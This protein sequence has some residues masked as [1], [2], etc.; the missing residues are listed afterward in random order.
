MQKMNILLNV[1]A[2][3]K[4]MQVTYRNN[5]LQGHSVKGLLGNLTEADLY[6]F[7]EFDVILCAN[8][9]TCKNLTK[10][11][12]TNWAGGRWIGD[13]KVLF[14][15]PLLHHFTVS[16]GPYLHKLHV[17][18]LNRINHDKT[19]L[20]FTIT[21]DPE[22]FYDFFMANQL[23]ASIL[24]Y[25]IETYE[26]NCLECTGYSFYSEE[27]G[28]KNMVIHGFKN[29]KMIR[30]MRECHAYNNVPVVTHNGCFDMFYCLLYKMPFRKWYFDT[31]YFWNA[32]QAELKKSLAF[33]SSTL[34]YDYE[35][36]KDDKRTRGKQKHEYNIK[37]CQY[38][39]RSLMAMLEIIPDWAIKQA[40]E[41]MLLA[42]PALYTRFEGFKVDKELKKK[43]FFDAGR[44]INEKE[45][46]LR[47]SADKPD[48]NINSPAQLNTIIYDKFRAVP[49]SGTRSTKV[50]TL[51]KLASHGG[52]IGN[53]CGNLLEYRKYQKAI[54]AYFGAELVNDRLL[55]N[56]NVDGTETG[57][58][59]CTLSALYK[60]NKEKGKKRGNV[61]SQIQNSPPYF[62]PCLIAD[63]G[64][65]LFN[66]DYGQAD[67]RGVAY[68]SN[69][70]DMITALED[71]SQMF[72]K[73]YIAQADE[74]KDFYCYI[75]SV[76]FKV[77]IHKSK[78]V[79]SSDYKL[80]QMQK[81]VCHQ[82][83]YMSGAGAIIE[84]CIKDLGVNFI[85][86]CMELLKYRGS[87]VQ[88]I[89][90]VLYLYFNMFDRIKPWWDRVQ[91]ELIKCNGL[92]ISPDGWYR[93]FHGDYNSHGVLRAAV[94]HLPQHL[95]VVGIN[96]AFKEFYYNHVLKYPDIYRL[97]GQVHDSIVGQAR[98]VYIMEAVRII[99]GYMHRPIVIH[100][101]EMWLPIE[102]SIGEDWGNMKEVTI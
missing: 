89:K 52:M 39:V 75:I 61:G 82:T 33:V 73:G 55:Y 99:Y 6:K 62:K 69:S 68:L 24:G 34:L 23:T 90:R 46:A 26:S 74:N 95:T 80:R 43:L 60:K 28:F 3:D 48:L 25:D 44:I 65:K 38:T 5:Y 8:P 92:L 63:T 13:T 2:Q 96:R 10:G 40:R 15:H 83:N 45:A 36:W 78:D 9:V 102:I 72:N 81:K 41:K 77:F 1:S 88:F 76:L 94:A 97:K 79:E 85:P 49:I 14:I 71:V 30:M 58:M 59:S 47:L 32:Y 50:N 64:F 11:A 4:N 67:A 17:R 84:S 53:F 20:Q 86:E 37:D 19:D 31:E 57:R 87:Q 101:R 18:K 56:L 35:Y 7:S 22:E 42:Y 54:S 91:Y 70:K 16:Y 51:L 100:G 12:L 27:H 29:A 21:D 66:L 98:E 93:Q